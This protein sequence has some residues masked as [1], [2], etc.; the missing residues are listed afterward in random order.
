MEQ[1]IEFLSNWKLWVILWIWFAVTTGY[2]YFLDAGQRTALRNES[3]QHDPDAA[4]YVQELR[5]QTALLELVLKNLEGI[6]RMVFGVLL[7][8]AI[9]IVFD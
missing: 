6:T 4:D 2:K 7:V 1:V 3:N 9:F 5:Y 8:A